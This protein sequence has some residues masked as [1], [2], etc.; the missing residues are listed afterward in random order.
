VTHLFLLLPDSC[1]VCCWGL[2]PVSLLPP[3]ACSLHLPVTSSLFL[4]IICFVCCWDLS[5]VVFC[6]VCCCDLS[7][8]CCSWCLSPVR[9]LLFPVTCPHAALSCQLSTCC[10]FL[11]PVRMLLFPF[12]CPHAALSC[13]LSTCC[14]FLPSVHMPLFPVTCPHAALSCHLFACFTVHL[15]MY[16]AATYPPFAAPDACNLSTCRSFL[17]PVRMPLFPVI[18]PHAAL[19]CHLSA[20]C[21]FLS[22]VWLLVRPERLGGRRGCCARA[23]NAAS[24]CRAWRRPPRAHTQPQFFATILSLC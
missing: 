15:H 7:S 6:F 17:S 10:S 4:P 5:P 19:S 18:C 20:C 21:S 12:S 1:Y 24:R 2:S 11:S 22:P 23:L 3:V 14:S 9:M 8:V 13:H 16:T